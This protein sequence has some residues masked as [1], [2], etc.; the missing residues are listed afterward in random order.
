MNYNK[1]NNILGWAVGLIA[2]TVYMMTKEATVSFW[3]CG[4][5]ISGAAKLEVVHSPGA[6]LFLMIGRLFVILFG[7]KNAA[8]AINTLSALSSGLTIMFLF[9]TITHFAKRILINSNEE[10]NQSNLIKVM[11][12]GL[13]GALAY[14]FSD[15]FWFSAVEG[16][17]YALSSFLTA[18]VFW[19]ILKWEDRLTNDQDPYADRWVLFIAFLM[20]LSIGV[21]LLNLLTIPAIVM[22]YYFK[23]YKVTQM[24][25]IWAFLIGCVITGVVQYG[26][27]QAVPILAK[28]MDILFVN[29]FGMPFNSGVLF[30]ILMI[31]A[32]AFFALRWAKKNNKYFLHLGT[33]CFVFILIGYSTFLTTIIRSNADVP[34]DMTN[35]DNAITLL[36]YL[37]REQYGNVPL[38]TGPDY[39][40][41]PTG[42]KDGKMEYWKGKEKYEELGM[43]RDEYT[44]ESSD[45]RL[46]PRIWDAN[47]PRHVSFYKSYLGLTDQ[48]EPS[49]ADNL[50]FFFRYQVN[51]MWWRYFMWNYAGRQNDYQN[52]MGE[53]HNGNWI[54]GI[55]PID[56]FFGRG[57]IDKMP[58]GFKNSM[59]RN[60][61]Y[62]LPL[63]LGLIGLY[64]HFQKDKK[65]A[66]IVTLL[67]F[68]T[69]LAIVIYLNNVPL[70]PRERD[71]AYA[72]STYAFAI[73]IGLGVMMVSDWFNKLKLGNLSPSLATALCLL[74]VPTL[75][76]SKEWDD[77]DRSDKTLA[78][79]SA[80]NY[81][82]SCEPN[83]I[84]FTEGDND[85]YPL[86]Y[87]QEVEGF[88]TDVRIV[89]I[90]LLGIDWYIDQLG[91]AI[92]KAAPVDLIW[93][94]E[95]YRG[96]KRNYIQHQDNK[97]IP[98]DKY[99]NLTEVLQFAGSDAPG[100]TL[101][102]QGGE[103]VNYFPTK[104][105]FIPVDK[106]L[107]LKNNVISP[108]DTSVVDMIQFEMPKNVAYK[109][110][111]AI[112]NILAANAWKRP[113]Y[114]SN[115][116]DPDHYEGLSEYLQLEGLAFKLIPIRTQGSSANMP[117][118]VNTDKVYDLFMNKFQFGN[119]EKSSIFYDQTNR[120][121][122]NTTRVLAFQLGDDLIRKGRNADAL[123]VIEKVTTS[124]SERSYPITLQQE[125]GSIIYLAN[126]AIRAGG[127]ELAQKLTD[128]LIKSADAEVSYMKSLKPSMQEA[129][130]DDVQFALGALNFIANE[131]TRSGMEDLG[132]KITEKINAL[133]TMAGLQ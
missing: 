89:N 49:T 27:I 119:A 92:N 85:T 120:R 72:G 24:G 104:K 8:L 2:T 74:A 71:Y 46:F 118:R 18:L 34:L 57:D 64:Y 32:A 9:W 48:D 14:T 45:K 15:T 51:Q 128:K 133:G 121:M 28:N 19:A 29:S 36:K 17:V 131:A 76:A 54:S 26:I 63:I 77:H 98:Q 38:I 103:R 90:S 21:H 68:F 122:L 99:I 124:I 53:P 87:A 82:N 116:I 132:K 56:K 88:R 78:L 59:A 83:A 52:L 6:P 40:S 50:S 42:M 43:K 129:K 115:S 61:L 113:I 31:A 13:V 3:D 105:F 35:P 70:Q 47:D 126:V 112:L 39:N 111:L 110:D 102:T 97:T 7:M 55:K 108:T 10:I 23:R 66:L 62:F 60:E 1:L 11:G 106:E 79:A 12:A 91:N 73:W 58:D 25:S 117:L 123:K 20:G 84:L 101:M 130:K 81:L 30:T 67:F 109:N 37:Q 41:K 16:E 94:S 100:A 65:N 93:K 69:G 95:Q 86:W 80:K 33:L 44:Y 127:K 107:C 96:E 4:E 22:V 5:F 75:M 114:F 125:N